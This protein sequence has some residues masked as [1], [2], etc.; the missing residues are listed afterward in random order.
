[1]AKKNDPKTAL[2]SVK[3]LINKGKHEDALEVLH[4]NREALEDDPVFHNAVGV[5][6][7]A[8][9]EHDA[10]VKAFLESVKKNPLDPMPYTGIGNSLAKNLQFTE[11]EKYFQLSLVVDE[12]YHDAIVG[13]G[14]AAFQRSDYEACEQHFQRALKSR[15]NSPTVLTNLAN[16]YAARGRHAEAIPLLERT[17]RLDPKNAQAHLNLGLMQLGMGQFDTGW[18]H[19]E[20]RFHEDNFI[21]QKF[22]DLPRWKGPKGAAAN[23]LVWAEQGVGDEIMFAS[24]FTE[25]SQCI[26]TF[27]IECDPRLKTLFEGAFPKL[28]FMAKANYASVT[29][30]DY[31]ISIASLAQVLRKSRD[32]FN[33]TP[34]GFLKPTTRALPPEAQAL[35]ASLPRPWIGVSWESY[36][37]TANFR[38]RKSIPA[39]QFSSLTQGLPGSIINLQFPNPHQHEGP[40]E[41]IIPDRVTTLPGIDLKND[42]E[43][44]ANLIAQLDSVITIGNS[45][46]HLC[47]AIGV[48]AT[49]LLPSVS[50]WRWG[51][52]GDRSPWYPNLVLARNSDPLDWGASLNALLQKYR[53]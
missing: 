6:L 47:G 2:E 18:N 16:S 30:I 53:T 10:A 27:V 12:N 23:V 36:A 51:F 11:A 8:L 21:Q 24:M 48:P 39:E 20:Y 50:D 9:R 37:L 3:S 33:Q 34:A 14:V 29:G 4:K 28:N 41:Q 15:P 26:E 17:L 52:S 46:A 49:V 42:L 44:L 22:K 19:Y 5:C 45:V 7:A 25:L 13:L 31:Q 1:M 40:S 35:L 38:Q 43:L 32:S